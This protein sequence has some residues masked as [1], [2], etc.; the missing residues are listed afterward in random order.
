MAMSLTAAQI[1]TLANQAAHTPA[2]TS[3]AGQKLN[4]ILQELCQTYDVAQARNIFTFS[5]TTGPTATGPYNLPTDY[6]RTQNGKQFYLYNGQPYFMTRIELWEYDALIQQPGFMDFPRNFTVDTST[7]P[8]Q[9]FVWPPASISVPVTVR[10]FRQ[11]PD[12]VTPETSNVVPWFPFTQYLITRLTGEMMALADDD[13][14]ADF[15][16]DD[17]EKNPQGAGVLLRRFL[18]MKDDPEGRTKTVELD[19]RRFSTQAQWNR[20]PNTKSIGW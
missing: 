2:F 13:R 16:T 4:A 1:V 6:L 18:N 20:L 19:R 10:Y 9:E 11:M 15:L 12:I 17:G 5:F 8:P 7:S 3:Q 14:A